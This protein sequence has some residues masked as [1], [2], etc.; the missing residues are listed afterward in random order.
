MP[1][2]RRVVPLGGTTGWAWAPAD[3]YTQDGAPHAQCGR[4]LLSSLLGSLASQGI[5]MK[6]AVELEWVVSHD[7]GDDDFHPAAR[8]PAYGMGRLVDSADYSRDLLVA[9]AESGVTV[10]Q[11]HPEYAPGQLEVSV[12]PEDPVSAA[13]TS[14][15]VRTVIA[16]G[17]RSSTA[18]AR[19]SHRRSPCPASAT[20][21]TSTSR[22][23]VMGRT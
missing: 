23:G 9:L 16:R 14:V 2:V 5:T 20:V 13:D 15:L 6:A 3:R 18:C 17:R 12:A 22:C 7:T 10:E 19:R 1:D 8:G 4:L 11:F 21:G